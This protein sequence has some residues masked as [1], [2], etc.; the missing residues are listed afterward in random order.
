MCPRL[1]RL[2]HKYSMVFKESLFRAG[3]G[4]RRGIFQHHLTFVRRSIYVSDTEVTP[5]AGAKEAS[6]NSYTT[7]RSRGILTVAMAVSGCPP[8]CK[9]PTNQ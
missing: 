9:M 4:S 5:S 2:S 3:A 6:R 1:A 7:R 8:N